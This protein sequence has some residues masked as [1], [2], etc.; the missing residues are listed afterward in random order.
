MTSCE[1]SHQRPIQDLYGI[2]IF[3]YWDI[4]QN[5]WKWASPIFST[6]NRG[7]IGF[8]YFTHFFPT[9]I[10]LCDFKYLLPPAYYVVWII[11]SSL[12]LFSGRFNLV[13]QPSVWA[14][15]LPEIGLHSRIYPWPF[16]LFYQT[17]VPLGSNLWVRLSVCPSLTDLLQT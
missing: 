11:E 17:Q 13:S 5:I 4:F 3:R 2:K 16:S 6:T 15:Q 1:I 12:N 9:W 14:N 7:C 10:K 8:E